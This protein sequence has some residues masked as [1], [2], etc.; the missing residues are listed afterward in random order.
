MIDIVIG[1]DFFAEELAQRLNAE[2][3]IVEVKDFIDGEKR[4]RLLLKSDKQ[5]EGK[6]ILLAVRSNRFKPSPND[7]IVETFILL[8]EIKNLG[9]NRIRLFWPWTF[10]SRQDEKFQLGEPLSLKY[11][12]EL[13]ESCG[14]KDFYTIHSH[15]YKKTVTLNNF[16]SKNVNVHDIS[17]AKIFVD[18]FRRRALENTI[19]ATP[20]EKGEERIN[21]IAEP[22][23]YE[24]KCLTK[25]RDTITGKIKIEFADCDVKDR[26][27]IIK[28]DIATTGGTIIDTYNG[29]IRMKPKRIFIALVH[30]LT[31]EGI[32]RLHELK[33]EEIVTT[34]SFVNESE[35]PRYFTELNLIPLIAKHLNSEVEK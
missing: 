24:T 21:E 28:D 35:R 7:T 14:V 10:Y 2:F 25:E 3:V 31:L 26:D 8:K 4:P 23:N 32:K 17:T 22:L 9:A 30:L 20:D 29:L 19:I 33:T 1:K 6:D 18:H 16:F 5:L 11:I 15:I 34:N 27:V 13:I 12:A